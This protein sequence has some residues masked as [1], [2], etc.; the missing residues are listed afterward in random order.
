[1]VFDVDLPPGDRTP[2]SNAGIDPLTWNPELAEWHPEWLVVHKPGDK[3]RPKPE[4]VSEGQKVDLL[5][6][7]ARSTG[8]TTRCRTD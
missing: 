1:M 5:H 6:P 2:R 7:S 8:R 4:E 3:S